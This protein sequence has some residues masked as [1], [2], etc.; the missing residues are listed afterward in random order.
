MEWHSTA[1]VVHRRFPAIRIE[2]DGEG[3]RGPA[4]PLFNIKTNLRECNMSPSV[5]GADF[6]R[7][8]GR[9]LPAGFTLVELLVVITIIGIL[10]ALLLPAVQSAR[11]SARRTQ[12]S[13]NLKQMGLAAIEHEQAQGTFPVGGWGWA[14][15]GDPNRGFSVKQPGGFFYNILP[16][17]EQ[18]PL[19]D[20]GM[21]LTGTPLGDAARQTFQTPVAAFNCPSR[22][23]LQAW[24]YTPQAVYN[25][26]SGNLAG[27][28]DYAANAGDTVIDAGLT[29]PGSLA[30]GDS[31]LP[32]VLASRT[33][34]GGFGTT[35]TMNQDGISFTLSAIKMAHITDGAS[36]TFLAGEKYL[37]PD[38]YY[39]GSIGGGDDQGW[40]LAYDWDTA[41]FAGTLLP[42]YQDQAG[43]DPCY[44]FGSAHA[45]AAGMVFCDG[46]VHAIGYGIDLT[47]LGYLANRADGKPIDWSKVQQ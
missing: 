31:V 30:A 36:N 40:D 39:G 38:R 35:V 27:R 8:R 24:P 5:R 13:N 20:L 37:N 7:N 16:F 32:Q 1:C 9:R 22:R 47:T 2:R 46:S 4:F 19:H 45:G 14:W 3:L 10:I 33:A 34:G 23:P 28:A 18:Q 29:G 12:C 41:R 6:P 42:V 26:S 11:E 15:S 17:M 21:G 44:Q 43:F 25:K